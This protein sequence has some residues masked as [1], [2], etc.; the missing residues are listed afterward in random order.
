MIY[1]LETKL[2]ENKSVFIALTSIYGVGQQ[3]ALKLCKKL[4]FSLN[5]KVND[6]TEEQVLEILKVIEDLNLITNNDLK[7]IKTQTLKTLVEIKSY[8]GLR[9]SKGLPV[10]GQRTHTNAKSARKNKNY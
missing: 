1:L 7:Q 6:L 9:R 4:G 3:T 2:N 10:R 5:F 8:R